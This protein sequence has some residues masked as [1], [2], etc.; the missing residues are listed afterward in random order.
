MEKIAKANTTNANSCSL[1]GSELDNLRTGSRMANRGCHSR[2]G[3]G[4][5]QE[6]GREPGNLETLEDVRARS[7]C[8]DMRH[9][10]FSQAQNLGRLDY[11]RKTS[12]GNLSTG[13]CFLPTTWNSFFVGSH[14]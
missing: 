5:W 4:G 1:K 10:A 9:V 14:L 6:Q 11:H 3:C 2:G 7:S 12:A 8:A 13:L